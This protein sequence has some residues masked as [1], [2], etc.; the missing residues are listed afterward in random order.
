MGVNSLG[1]YPI[2]SG[3]HTNVIPVNLL[4][5]WAVFLARS[6]FKF[7]PAW[8]TAQNGSKFIGM[9]PNSIREAYKCNLS[10]FTPIFT[11]ISCPVEF[12]WSNF[13][14][15]R[16]WNTAQNGSKFIGMIPNSIRDAY[17]CNPSEFTPILSSISC[18]V[19]F[20][21]NGIPVEL[22]IIPMQWIQLASISMDLL[23]IWPVE[24]DWAWNTAQN[25]YLSQWIYS[26]FD[27]SN[28]K[29]DQAWN[30]AQIG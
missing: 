14:F 1:W 10:E 21:R 20:H 22:G 6:N 16:A 29:F 5:F 11:S 26:Q 30:T 12:D 17:K 15:D 3:R 8:N 9:I 18:L 2:W 28:F 27:Q 25:G 7:D 4:P 19:E 23:P 13:K 24:F